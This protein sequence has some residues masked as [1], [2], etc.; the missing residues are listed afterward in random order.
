MIGIEPRQTIF[1]HV[2][3][4]ADNVRAQ[5]RRTMEHFEID[6]LSLE[7]MQL[8]VGPWCMNFHVG[9]SEGR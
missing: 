7:D 9:C 5:L 6:L 4:Q 1:H 2:V 3:L 8:S